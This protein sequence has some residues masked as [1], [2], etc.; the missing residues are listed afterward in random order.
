MPKWVAG[1]ALGYES[2]NEDI[3]FTKTLSTIFDSDDSTI[4]DEQILQT[5]YRLSVLAMKENGV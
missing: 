2:S 4:M 5:V 3:R 1:P